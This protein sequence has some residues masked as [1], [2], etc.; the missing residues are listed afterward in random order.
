M[1]WKE[2]QTQNSCE[3]FPEQI[4]ITAH[5]GFLELLRHDYFLEKFQRN[6]FILKGDLSARYIVY[7]LNLFWAPEQIFPENA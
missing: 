6:P 7:S 4:Q 3:L 5:Y 2:F 1:S